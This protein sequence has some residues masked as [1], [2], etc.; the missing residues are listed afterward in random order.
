MI[1]L[2]IETSCDETALSIISFE[3]ESR[4]F[5]IL[6]NVLI[7]QIDIH[8]EHGGVFPALAK[9]EHAKNLVPLLEAAIQEAAIN[10]ND[11]D[12][13]EHKYSQVEEIL[14]REPELFE[15]IANFIKT[16]GVP[17]IDLIFVTHG[18]GLA[19]ALWVG[20]NFARA[21][22]IITGAGI[23]PVNHMEGHIT[24]IIIPH[25]ADRGSDIA[26][27]PN[28]QFPMLS[29]L[30]SGGHTQLVLVN[31]WGDYTIIGETIDDAVG[32]AFDKVARLLGL[33]YPGGPKLSKMAEKGKEDESIN[34]PRP[35]IH[36]KD[37]RFS[38]S[39]LKTAARYLIQDMD[40]NNTLDQQAKAD[41][42]R[43]FESA[44]TDVLVTKTSSA[45]E[46]YAIQGLI[47][48]GGVSANTSIRKAFKNVC[49]DYDI[50][51]F[52]PDLSLCGDNSLMIASAGFLHY[53][54]NKTT[55]P[56]SEVA[57]IA[58]LKL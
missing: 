46:E 43:E 41:I 44:V 33:E 5:T 50:P 22:S 36:S 39:G 55:T 17:V 31:D 13:P 51:L 15:H 12:I 49:S 23:V 4:S 45:I 57:A 32:E 8:K 37:Y 26:P 56:K 42:A 2:A 34:L 16:N 47:I 24:S 3:Q 30:V 21:L 19:P 10:Y 25:A 27:A 9:R 52:I 38:F 1:A 58:N 20:V 53:Q 6:S 18:P 40:T 11:K 7:S 48:A 54:K 28:I 35:M 29:L 14:D